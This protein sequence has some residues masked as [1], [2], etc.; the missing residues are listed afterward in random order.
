MH[1][2]IVDSCEPFQPL[3]MR[4]GSLLRSRR[5][6]RGH[7]ESIRM[8][9]GIV[10]PHLDYVFSPTV[11]TATQTTTTRSSSSSNRLF[12]GTD[13]QA[14]LRG[15]SLCLLNLSQHIPRFTRTDGEGPELLTK[16]YN[17]KTSPH[18]LQ[19]LFTTPYPKLSKKIKC[20]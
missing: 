17:A 9:L 20:K 14:P 13:Q 10:V 4:Y 15:A 12:P 3:T 18:L 6:P 2:Q 5:S 7:T 16:S 1:Q 19:R 8:K 11:F